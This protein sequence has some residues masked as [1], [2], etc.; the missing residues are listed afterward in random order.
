MAIEQINIKLVVDTKTGEVKLKNFG[1]QAVSTLGQ[2]EKK[3]GRLGNVFNRLSKLGEKVFFG[4]QGLKALTQPLGELTQTANAFENSARKLQ[5]TAK[6]TGIDFN[7][8]KTNSDAARESLALN[9]VQS[10]ELTIALSKL[11]NKAGDITKTGTAMKRLLDIAAAQGLNAQQA[12]EA[13]NQAI[14][15]I[16]EGT[17]K[18]FQKN[19]SVIYKEYAQ[20]IG[21]SAGKMTDQQKAQALLN[22]VMTDGLKVQGEYGRFLETDAGRTARAAAKTEEFKAKLGALINEVYV[23]LISIGSDLLSV[24]SGLEKG[25]Q[26]FVLVL[27]GLGLAAFKV[28]PAINGINSATKLLGVGIK[29]ALGWIS[30]FIAAATLIYT[31]WANNLF[32]FRELLQKTWVY[33]KEW[34]AI[35]WE[36]VKGWVDSVINGFGLVAEIV[37][38]VFTG[39]FIGAVSDV[40]KAGALFAGIAAERAKKITKIQEDAEKERQ[41]I[42]ERYAREEAALKKK[43]AAKVVNTDKKTSAQTAEEKANILKSFAKFEAK[44]NAMVKSYGDKRRTA[45]EREAAEAMRRADSLADY[46]F[47]SGRMSLEQYKEVLKERAE[48]ARE[49]HGAESEEYFRALDEMNQADEDFQEARLERSLSTAE[50]IVGVAQYV[51]DFFAQ[52]R[53]RRANDETRKWK[54][55]LKQKKAALKLELDNGKISQKEYE[56]RLKKLDQE[57]KKRTAKIEEDRRKRTMIEKMAAAAQIMIDAILTA[58]KVY[59]AVVDMFGPFGIPFGAALA[60][61]VLGFGAAKAAQVNAVAFATGGEVD[62][63][64]LGLVGEAGPEI[65]AP[66]KSFIEVVQSLISGGQIAREAP[67]PAADPGTIGQAVR[68]ALDEASWRVDIDA[69]GLAVVLETGNR[70]LSDLEF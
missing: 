54:E 46:M 12:I 47:Q 53:E 63:P 56:K 8:L 22:A 38:K 48:Y 69:D 31:A 30:L 10:T 27:G 44:L 40:Q 11:G 45:A 65:I 19:P 51:G 24:F 55:S 5:A 67:Q 37:R 4:L 39:D 58:M 15:G 52:Q 23:P 68:K 25:T 29:G 20:Q 6:L 64:T 2:V 35:A 42:R 26:R 66:K 43:T 16:D 32:G 34:A 7:L 3:A 41:G 18:L 50:M 9:Q 57:D 36:A 13:I 1:D 59:A 60:A 70:N 49:I 62:K 17:D 28:I 33:I 21:I 14:L 61:T